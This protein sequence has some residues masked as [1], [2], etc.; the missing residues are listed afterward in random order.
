MKRYRLIE[1]V[2]VTAM[3]VYSSDTDYVIPAGTTL[4][5]EEIKE[6][7][8]HDKAIPNF[9]GVNDYCNDCG[10]KHMTTEEIVEG[11]NNRNKNQTFVIRPE[12]ESPAGYTN[13]DQLF[14]PWKGHTHII[15]KDYKC[16]NDCPLYKPLTPKVEDD[17]LGRVE[18]VFRGLN[19]FYGK[20]GDFFMGWGS[21]LDSLAIDFRE[22]FPNRFIEEVKE[23]KES[24]CHKC[25]KPFEGDGDYCYKHVDQ[26][27][28]KKV[29]LSPIEGHHHI[30]NQDLECINDCPL[31][32][33]LTPKD[34]GMRK[35]QAMCQFDY[36]LL[37]ERNTNYLDIYHLSDEEF[38]RLYQQ[39]LKQ[40]KD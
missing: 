39:F 32:Q 29:I 26:P 10:E 1:E 21:A 22:E 37:Y 35:G 12:T 33:P 40:Y 8:T 16:V 11:L 17:V 34:C 24:V 4:E 3:G 30:L 18:R 6:I 2:E 20:D 5:L 25:F 38:D 27:K 28:E 15:S 19:R 23:E 31:D 7:C 9:G 14:P 13:I 36:W